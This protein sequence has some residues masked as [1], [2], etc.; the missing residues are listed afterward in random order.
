VL[1]LVAVRVD[2]RLARHGGEVGAVVR[3]I[4]ACG[5]GHGVVIHRQ[6]AGR[7]CHSHGV[8]DG[9]GNKVANVLYVQACALA[10]QIKD[11]GRLHS[12]HLLLTSEKF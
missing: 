9:Q 12:P 8:R 3:D 10:K 6:V 1:L 11:T 7:G 2:G 5:V 4:S